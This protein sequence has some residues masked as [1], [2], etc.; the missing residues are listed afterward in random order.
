MDAHVHKYWEMW[1]L[2]FYNFQFT[3]N[4]KLG[5]GPVRVQGLVYLTVYFIIEDSY[6]HIFD[7]IN[8]KYCQ[9]GSGPTIGDFMLCVTVISL[10]KL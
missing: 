2:Y 5:T 3:I 10:V 6:G 4:D 9:L 1:A 7:I 8:N